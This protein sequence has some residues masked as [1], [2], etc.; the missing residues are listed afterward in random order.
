METRI[1]LRQMLRLRVLRFDLSLTLNAE[2][3]EGVLDVDVYWSLRHDGLPSAASVFS[4]A[5]VPLCLNRK[6]K[7][8]RIEE[9]PR[10]DRFAVNR[11]F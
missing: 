5:T 10:V 6:F 8:P 7:T 11:L 4:G 2:A 3:R 9:N 1:P